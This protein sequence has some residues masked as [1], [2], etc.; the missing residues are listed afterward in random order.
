MMD[1]NVPPT[2]TTLVADALMKAGKDFDML[3]L[4]QARHGFG[5]DSPY[6][7]R[8]R[9]DYFV[10]N[11]RECAQPKEYRIGQPRVVP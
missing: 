9:W 3:M 5:A 6:I 10:T 2:N 7:M 4:P 8:R 11:L 1:D